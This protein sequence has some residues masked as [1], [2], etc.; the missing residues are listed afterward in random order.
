MG[1]SDQWG[2]ITTGGEL[3][4]RKTG[5]EAFALTIPLITKADGGKFGKT[6]SGNVWLDPARTSPYEFYQFWLNTSDADAVNFI[7]VFTLLNEEEVKLLI[8]EHE[9]APHFRVLQ[10]KLAEE[11][12][13]IVHS[14]EEFENAVRASQI[15]FGKGTTED[16]MR[17]D[18]KTFLSVF[19]G[20]PVYQ[21]SKGILERGISLSS[22]L[23][24]ETQ[25]VPSK[26]EMR[27]TIQGGGV[28]LNKVKVE[29]PEINI[30]T[31]NLLNQK[32]LLVQKG[33]KNYYIITVNN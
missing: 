28:S 2:N 9:K 29:D 26:G 3:I 30:T 15:L 12:T 14:R 17:L 11:L 13:V 6:E 16:L 20:V 7:K 27:R 10:K 1:G 33:K 21:I 22:L 5:G 24:E 18:E 8:A 4:R 19:N 31:K 23:A 32:Y 25:V